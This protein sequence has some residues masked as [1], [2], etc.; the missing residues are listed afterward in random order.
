VCPV[1]LWQDEPRILDCIAATVQRLSLDPSSRRKTIHDGALKVRED[2]T[3]IHTRMNM[4]HMRLC[5]SGRLL[6]PHV[7]VQW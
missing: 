3:H 2:K 4:W 1:S 6:A 5:G 7:A